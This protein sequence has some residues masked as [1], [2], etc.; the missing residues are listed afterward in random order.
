[1]ELFPGPIT[2]EKSGGFS[3]TFNIHEN[4]YTS[5]L[6]R[7]LLTSRFHINEF[8]HA[9]NHLHSGV[10]YRMKDLEH[11]GKELHTGVT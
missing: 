2:E 5:N 1:V 10:K 9:A 11:F 8:S 6:A 3:Q 7:G 4:F